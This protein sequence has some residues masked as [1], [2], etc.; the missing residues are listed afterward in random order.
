[1][2][3][4]PEFLF[5]TSSF[6]RFEGDYAGIFVAEMAEAY[7]LRGAVSVLAPMDARVNPVWLPKEVSVSRF[8]SFAGSK[9]GP[10]YGPGGP[11]NLESPAIRFRAP[12]A[13]ASMLRAA[14]QKAAHASWLVSHWMVPAGLCG[15]LLRHSRRRH[16]LIVHSGGFYFLRQQPGGR[17]LARWILRRS[18]DVIAVSPHLKDELLRL[19]HVEHRRA[20][21]RK[22]RVIPMGLPVKRYAAHREEASVRQKRR[23]I[24]A[25]GRMTPIKGFD[26]L[27]EAAVGLDASLVI[28]GDGPERM[29]LETRCRTLGLRAVFPGVLSPEGM[30]EELGKASVFVLP[31]RN[32]NGRT[33]GAPRVLLEAMA[34]GAPILAADSGGVSSLIRH[35]ENGILFEDDDALRSALNQILNDA[36]SAERLSEAAARRAVD[37]DWTRR[38]DDFFPKPFPVRS[39]DGKE[40]A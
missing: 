35:G 30:A 38:I 19:F 31:S 40:P 4:L 8:K 28:A 9:G 6:P 14:R 16:Q 23:R 27:V 36:P 17:R 26:R 33:E 25:A 24:F 5:L 21:D 10:F 7:A 20:M 11:E 12:L 39:D 37:F 13:L 22:I 15:A 34:S 3:A 32:L 1:M 2:S 29:R 18:D